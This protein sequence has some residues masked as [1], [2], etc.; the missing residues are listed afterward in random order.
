MLNTL[1]IRRGLRW[2]GSIPS[3]SELGLDLQNVL[4]ILVLVLLYGMAG[5]L[6]Q[7]DTQAA[8]RE[9][10][11]AR[12]DLNRA[13]LLACLNGGS[14]GLYVEHDNGVRQYLVCGEHY[15]VSD[16]NIRKGGA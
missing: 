13:A 2:Q 15:Y 7:A 9:S 11:D 4:I 14:P 3:A 12:A 6:D 5:A 1:R 8:E 16:E 10:A